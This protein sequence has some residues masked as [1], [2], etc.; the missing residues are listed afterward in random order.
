M[1]TYKW[2]WY[3]KEKGNYQEKEKGI[4]IRNLTLRKRNLP[5]PRDKLF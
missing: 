3:G 5:T 2:K 1:I 4:G